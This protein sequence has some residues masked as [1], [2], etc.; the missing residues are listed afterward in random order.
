MNRSIYL[1]FIILIL[2]TIDSHSIKANNKEIADDLKYLFQSYSNNTISLDV[3]SFHKFFKDFTLNSL[4][5][6]NYNESHLILI[7]QKCIENKFKKFESLTLTWTNNTLID[8]NSFG[9]ISSYLISYINKCLKE[10]VE[11]FGEDHHHHHD[12]IEE[13]SI[14]KSILNNI[15]FISK[16]SKLN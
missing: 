9:K 15:S 12:D 8:T 10:N 5:L 7:K 16:E 4:E 11:I 3:E 13:K 2:H 14:W 6:F 1:F